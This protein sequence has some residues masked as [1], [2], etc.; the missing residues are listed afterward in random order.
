[1]S[2]GCEGNSDGE[3]A[4]RGIEEVSCS[5][6]SLRACLLEREGGEP[7]KSDDVEG[8]DRRSDDDE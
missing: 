7:R 5:D 1:M 6:G 8:F 4:V 3:E 2:M